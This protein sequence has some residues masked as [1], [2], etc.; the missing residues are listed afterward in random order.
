MILYN[1]IDA[2][3]GSTDVLEIRS[4]NDLVW[5]SITELEEI[6]VFNDPST[7]DEIVLTAEFTGLTD[8]NWG[9]GSSES[10]TSG[11]Q[12]THTYQ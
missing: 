3:I 10:L 12:V 4:G 6:W 7:N 1:A 9:D 5:S 2:K 8:V 11:T